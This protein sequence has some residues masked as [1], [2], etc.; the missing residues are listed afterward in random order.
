M[1]HVMPGFTGGTNI[2]NSSRRMSSH[3]DHCYYIKKLTTLDSK[4]SSKISDFFGSQIYTNGVDLQDA[5]ASEDC[6]SMVTQ[7]PNC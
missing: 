4:G 5:E 2:S 1:T 3:K 6:S 7:H